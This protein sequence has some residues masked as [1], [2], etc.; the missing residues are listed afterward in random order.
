MKQIKRLAVLLAAAIILCACG[1]Q[2]ALPSETTAAPGTTA[3]ALTAV[4]GT[5]APALTAIPGTTALPETTAVPETTA[6]PETAPP[7]P[8]PVEVVTDGKPN[9]I[10]IC[11]EDSTTAERT[12]AAAIRDT[13]YSLTGKHP[14]VKTERGTEK[15]DPSAQE[16][17]VGNCAQAEVTTVCSTMRYNQYGVRFCGNK[18]VV[19]AFDAKGMELATAELNKALVKGQTGKTLTLSSDYTVLGTSNE[20]IV[21]HLPNYSGGTVRNVVDCADDN[22]MLYVTDTTPDAFRA[23]GK[24]LEAAGFKLYTQREAANNLFATYTNAEYNLHTY[25]TAA[26]KEARIIIEP[27]SALP[28]RAEDTTTASDKYEPA[29]R[30]VGLEYNYNGDG[31]LQN[32]L[33]LIFRLPDGRL[34]VVD[35]GTYN[36][37]SAGLLYK[38]IRDMAPD[39]NNIVIAAWVLTHAHGDHTGGYNQFVEVYAG[40]IKVERVIHNFTTKAQYAL[41]ND[42]GRD[43]QSR[44]NAKKLADEVIKAHTGQLYHFGGATMEILY[45]FD[46]FEPEPLPYHN[47]TSLIFR[48]SMGGQTV[49]VLGDAYTVSN[50]I[51]S[52][53]WGSYLKSDIVQIAHHGYIGGTVEVY[54]LIDADTALWPLGSRTV[55]K[56]SQRTEN[57][58]MLKNTRDVFVA[59]DDVITLTLPYTPVGNNEKFAG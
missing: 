5:T 21:E 59:A 42:Y 37:R 2:G 25:Y 12:A 15:P 17:L 11:P 40:R 52:R 4:P 44:E 35:G 57:A 16:I 24:Q 39:P 9:F 7:A 38:N 1:K 50:D 32:G 34:I 51:A 29:V 22:R 10:I 19:A 54:T 36:S 20:N 49:M 23:Y 3:P 30:M 48:I 45:T 26:D 46:D 31:Y 8:T 47:T 58:F 14:S 27:T 28:P 33:M 56:N 43:D 18:L 53:M 55:E 6:P 13:I 41:V